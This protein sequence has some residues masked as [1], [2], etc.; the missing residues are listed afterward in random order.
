MPLGTIALPLMNTL[1][2]LQKE[3]PPAAREGP[4]ISNVGI[5]WNQQLSDMRKRNSFNPPLDYV[6][7][8]LKE[9][10]GESQTSKSLPNPQAPSPSPMSKDV[11]HNQVLAG[12][13]RSVHA[14]EHA[15]RPRK[16][17]LV[18]TLAMSAVGTIILGLIFY[19]VCFERKAEQK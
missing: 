19:F 13:P 17:N 15:I 16:W 5:K 10:L 12:A 4:E 2:G 7:R 8:L 3:V 18:E 11:C 1:P 9:N 6:G 14:P